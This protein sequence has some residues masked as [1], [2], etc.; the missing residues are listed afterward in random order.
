MDSHVHL[1]WIW[2]YSLL[3]LLFSDI[4]LSMCEL[5]FIFFFNTVS[6][7]INCKKSNLGKWIRKTEVFVGNVVTALL[8]LLPSVTGVA[9]LYC[10]YC[11]YH[12]H[13]KKLGCMRARNYIY[14]FRFISFHL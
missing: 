11:Y 9:L 12:H 2:I 5:V 13:I 6:I 4:Q 10:V 1:I 3:L 14:G 7:A 8:L